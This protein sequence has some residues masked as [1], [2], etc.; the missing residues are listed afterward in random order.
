MSIK[1]SHIL[2]EDEEEAK[3]VLERVKEGENINELALEYS[4]DPTA[5]ENKGDL[6]YF[7]KGKW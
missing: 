5:K 4:K 1:A 2:L 7:R 6:G 3:K